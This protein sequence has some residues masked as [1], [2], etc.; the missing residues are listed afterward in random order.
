MHLP[1][2]WGELFQLSYITRDLDAAIAHCRETLGITDFA[3]SQTPAAVISGGKRQVLEVRAAIANYGRHQFELIEPVSGPIHHYENVL[4]PGS[5][6]INFHHVAIA[7][8]GPWENWLATVAEIEA[9]GDEIAF[10][11]PPEPP[12]KPMVGFCYVDTRA[13]LGHYTEYL[14]WDPSLT[15]T[16]PFID[17][18]A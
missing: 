14:W 9:S 16:G 12:E 15:G 6:L 2:R 13:R 17:L 1:S 5:G 4:G 7:V 18:D 3:I 10:I 11:H 8:R